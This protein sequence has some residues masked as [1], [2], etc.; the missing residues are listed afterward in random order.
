MMIASAASKIPPNNSVS[1]KFS[2]L[3]K[4]VFNNRACSIPPGRKIEAQLCVQATGAI[5][6]TYF[7][8]QRMLA[9]H[10]EK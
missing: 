6:V 2:V 1:F 5:P 7:D 3:F 9:V 8:T 4:V 10:P